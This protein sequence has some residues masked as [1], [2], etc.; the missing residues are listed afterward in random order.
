MKT[1]EDQGERQVQVLKDLKDLNLEDHQK[2]PANDYEDK[3]LIS[4]EREIFKNIYNK[5]LDKIKELSEKIDD[6]NLV[7]SIISTGRTTDFSKKDDPLTFLIKIKKGETLIEE[8][9]ES[10][11]DFKEQKKPLKKLNMLFNGRNDAINFIEG[12]GSLI[13]EAK[14]K[15]DEEL[16]EKDGTGL[17]ILNPKQ[18]LQRLRIAQ[19]NTNIK[20]DTIFMNSEN[21]KTS[22]LHVLILKLLVN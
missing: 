17:K 12:Y 6:N 3:L 16:K 18:L 5:S 1:I 7:F 13:L 14:R 8:P 22:E 21:S 2:Q 15:A 10:R 19:Y 4:K 11:K 9:K 20:M